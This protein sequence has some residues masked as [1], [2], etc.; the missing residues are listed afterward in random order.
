MLQFSRIFHQKL[1]PLFLRSGGSIAHILLLNL[2]YIAE[3][4]SNTNFQASEKLI[5]CS[6]LISTTVAYAP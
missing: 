2:R 1:P 4:Q 5:T 6:H 3:I